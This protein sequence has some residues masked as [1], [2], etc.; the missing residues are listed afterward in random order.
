MVS[1]LVPNLRA[2]A[3][4]GTKPTVYNF[5]PGPAMMPQAV[6]EQVQAEF[7]DW[8]GR[9]IS[10]LEMGHRTPD[11]ITIAEESEADLRELMSI[12]ADYRVLFLQGGATSQFAMVPMNLLAGGKT[13]DY[14]CTGVWSVKAYQEALRH[15]KA[16]LAASSEAEDFLTIPPRTEWR[17]SDDPAYLYYTSNETITGLQFPDLPDAGAVPLVSDMTS[18]FLSRPLDISRFGVI[19]AGA[20]KNIAP[21]GLVVVVI[22]ADLIGEVSSHLPSLYDYA[23]MAESDSMYNTPPTFSWYMAGLVF[24]WIKQQGGVAVM[25]Q[26]SLRRSGKLY[27]AIDASG[28]YHNPVA[29]EYRSRMNVAF[30][31]SDDSL[32]QTFLREAEENGLVALKGHRVLGGMRASMYNAL[33]EEGVDALIGFMREFER[34][35]G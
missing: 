31:L 3:R 35:Y 8:H 9:G 6:M 11:F 24:K 12:P 33:P 18:D 23:I 25:E 10:A 29:V 19:F 15:G 30:T 4:Q 22:R 16:H 2:A 32:E 21:A 7:L 17:L 34:R 1:E 27:Q 14:L 5:S 20:Q 26:N 13:A 28:F